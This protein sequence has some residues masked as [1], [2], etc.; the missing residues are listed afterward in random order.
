MAPPRRR[1]EFS[2]GGAEK[3]AELP[4]RCFAAR[5]RLKKFSRRFGDRKAL[6]FTLIQDG[7]R[8]TA[9][10]YHYAYY[11]DAARTAAL[12]PKV[13]DRDSTAIGKDISVGGAGS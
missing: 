11:G 7:L 9:A 13:V 12:R 2:G 3:V 8:H 5:A 4:V 10:T 6:G 1:N